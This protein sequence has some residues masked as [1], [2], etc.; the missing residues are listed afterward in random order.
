MN[1]KQLA[2]R[3]IYQGSIYQGINSSP[4]CGDYSSGYVLNNAGTN[5]IHQCTLDGT[6]PRT[7][8]DESN[9]GA[10]YFGWNKID[11]K[12]YCVRYQPRE[13]GYDSQYP[14]DYD[15][16]PV[17]Y[18]NTN[19]NSILTPE[20]S[21]DLAAKGYNFVK[22]GSDNNDCWAQLNNTIKTPK[23]D[24]YP[25]KVNPNFNTYLYAD[26]GSNWSA[27]QGKPTL[28]LTPY[29]SMDQITYKNMGK[30]D[31]K[32]TWGDPRYRYSHPYPDVTK[33]GSEIFCDSMIKNPL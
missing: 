30:I 25:S 21:N 16:G 18:C 14:N 22:C 31:N 28:C 32:G 19:C 12:Y 5:C 23:V 11:D 10:K 26:Y 9:S 17:S 33:P 6:D 27:D 8:A 20:E 24:Y 4:N 2:N 3:H 13:L 1:F 15:S 7:K 29:S